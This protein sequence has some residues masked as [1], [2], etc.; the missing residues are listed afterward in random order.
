M[1]DKVIGCSPNV[2]KLGQV[3]HAILLYKGIHRCTNVLQ[4]I[5]SI[6]YY[7]DVYMSFIPA[8]LTGHDR[9]SKQLCRLSSQINH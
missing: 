7:K 3:K 8:E 1:N 4:A 9:Y 2:T 5:A 6:T